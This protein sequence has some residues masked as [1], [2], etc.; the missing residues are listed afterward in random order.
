MCPPPLKQSRPFPQRDHDNLENEKQL[1]HGMCV[2][3]SE[4]AISFMLD[5]RVD[6]DRHRERDLDET[7]P[8]R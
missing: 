8:S 2:F 6:G 5:G 4:K 3:G 1:I 7:E